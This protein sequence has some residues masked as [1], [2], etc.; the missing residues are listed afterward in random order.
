LVLDVILSDRLDFVGRCIECA[1]RGAATVACPDKILRL[2][3]ATIAQGN[4]TSASKLQE[5]RYTLDAS[6]S[7]IDQAISMLKVVEVA[8][9]QFISG[10]AVIDKLLISDRRFCSMVEP[11]IF[12]VSKRISVLCRNSWSSSP[13]SYRCLLLTR[14]SSLETVHGQ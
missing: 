7:L 10:E 8:A 9:L 12:I 13:V 5:K 6:L 14:G 1:Y 4:V 11:F 3:S 2:L